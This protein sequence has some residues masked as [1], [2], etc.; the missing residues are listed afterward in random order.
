MKVWFS[1]I[2]GHGHFFPMIPLARALGEAGHQVTF[3][4]SASYGEVVRANGF[5][6]LAV[7]PDYTQASAKGDTTDP[8]VTRDRVVKMMFM[9]APPLI[10]D[11]LLEQFEVQRPDVMLV[12]PVE[13]GA[14]LAG[15]AAGIP[16]GA[17]VNAVRPSR[18]PGRVPFDFDEREAF[19]EEWIDGPIARFRER[20]GLGD[21]RLMFDEMPFDRTLTLTMAPPS[22]DAWP[23]SWQSHT[24]HLLR[25]EIHRSDSDD[26]W[27]EALP[28]DRPIVSVTLG[29]LFGSVE[30]YTAVIEAVL[31]TGARVVAATGLDLDITHPRLSTTRWVSMDRLMERSDVVVHHGGWGSTVAGLATGTPAVVMPL[32]ADQPWQAARLASVGA[33]VQVDRRRIAEEVPSAIESV[34]DDPV[35]GMNARRLH[36][37]IEAMPAAPEVVPLVEQLAEEGP[38]V[39][40][41]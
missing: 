5:A 4:T 38:P 31:G 14:M 15:E 8:E 13:G 26:G 11:S 39:L 28:D 23:I 3:C 27:L 16:F 18:L 10:L 29:T 1:I 37:E 17:V 36:Q 7:G 30:L 25:P 24:A 35:Y 20:A 32:G 2:P 34:I 19:L 22:L 33:A 6:S 9:D 12:D 40:N 41:R 21:H